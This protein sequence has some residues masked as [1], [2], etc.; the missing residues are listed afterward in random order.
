LLFRHKDFG[1]DSQEPDKTLIYG[2]C[3]QVLRISHRISFDTTFHAV[4]IKI[5]KSRADSPN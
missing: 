2:G 5:P 1:A 3:T 4:A